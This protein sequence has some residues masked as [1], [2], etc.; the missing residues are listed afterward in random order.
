MASSCPVQS[1]GSWKRLTEQV[2]PGDATND[3]AWATWEYYDGYPPSLK[4]TS[5][6]KREM[7]IPNKASRAQITKMAVR[8]RRYNT[9]NNTAH[10]FTPTQIGQSDN[11]DI[12]FK[13]NYLPYNVEKRRQRDFQ[14]TGKDR[15]RNDFTD[16]STQGIPEVNE[17]VLTEEE[18]E[19]VK[20]NR[21]RGTFMQNPQGGPT[22]LTADNW[23]TAQTAGFKEFFGEYIIEPTNEEVMAYSNELIENADAQELDTGEPSV[24]EETGIVNQGQHEKQIGTNANEAA[25]QGILPG[26]FVSMT[27]QEFDQLFPNYTWHDLA[28]KEKIVQ[29]IMNGNI[30][31]FC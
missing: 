24:A 9:K 23:I 14:R 21:S 5:A 27:E 10:S 4:S 30:K 2:S 22:A 3:L 15:T 25:K 6:L 16:P 26:D 18:Q 29:E 28:T 1:S 31:L 20:V 17:R 19:I 7:G 12:D 11:Y 13:P 8:V